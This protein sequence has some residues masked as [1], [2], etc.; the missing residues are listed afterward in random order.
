MVDLETINRQL[1]A[2]S[3]SLQEELAAQEEELACQ[4]RELEQLRQNCYQH[5]TIDHQQEYRQKGEFGMMDNVKMLQ[6]E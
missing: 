4:K 2:E 3:Q 6:E 5:E 1:K